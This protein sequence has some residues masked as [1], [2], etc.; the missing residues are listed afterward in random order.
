MLSALRG[1]R[2]GEPLEK[3]VE[4]TPEHVLGSSEG[5]YS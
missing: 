1:L 5:N 4:V 3:L 2:I